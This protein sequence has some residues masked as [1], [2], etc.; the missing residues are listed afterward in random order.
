VAIIGLILFPNLVF[1][2]QV[3][4]PLT[5]GAGSTVSQSL[6]ALPKGIYFVQFKNNNHILFTKL[7]SHL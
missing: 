1:G 2:Q 4:A 3:F 6:T 7:L 5:V